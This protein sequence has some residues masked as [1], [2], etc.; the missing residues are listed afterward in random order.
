MTHVF[1]GDVIGAHLDDEDR[2]ERHRHSLLA[3]PAALA[4]GCAAGE[5]CASDQGL[6]QAPNLGRVFVYPGSP[7]VVEQTLFVIEAKQQMLHGLRATLSVIEPKCP[8]RA[9]EQCLDPR[10]STWNIALSLTPASRRQS[11]RSS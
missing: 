11:E 3:G 10:N 4:A 7:D 8:P 1:A 2:L 6:E 9:T 5:P